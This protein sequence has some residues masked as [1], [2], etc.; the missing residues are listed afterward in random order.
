M[1]CQ[2]N[3]IKIKLHVSVVVFLF[4][5]QGCGGSYGK[6]VNEYEASKIEPEKT[7]KEQVVQYLGEPASKT[8]TSNGCEIWTYIHGS[9][10]V[11]PETYIPVV[12]AFA[13]GADT[14]S[15]SFIVN[16]SQDGKVKDYQRTNTTTGASLNPFGGAK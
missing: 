6:K 15:E 8:K 1:V 16:F 5:L 12:G 13:G 3:N 7:T 14:A 11:R 9:T 10:K 4:L 2:M